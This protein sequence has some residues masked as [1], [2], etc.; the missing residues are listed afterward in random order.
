[1]SDN[2]RLRILDSAAG[3]DGIT[4]RGPTGRVDFLGP[5]YHEWTDEPSTLMSP[6]YRL[7]AALTGPHASVL[8]ACE[9]LDVY[10]GCEDLDAVTK[11]YRAEN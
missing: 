3:L 7:H 2:F 5:C 11:M 9:T 6:F 10:A 8:H 1:M 4:V